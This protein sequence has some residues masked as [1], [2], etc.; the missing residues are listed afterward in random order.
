MEQIVYA[1]TNAEFLNE[2]FGTNYKAWMKC[3]WNYDEDT[4]VWMV[5][6]DDK[7]RQGWKNTIVDVETVREDYLG[8]EEDKLGGHRK[9]KNY[10]RIVVKKDRKNGIYTVLGLYAYDFENS[11]EKNKRI[12]KK[13]SD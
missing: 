3:G 13:I 4:I 2:A 12:W 9:L 8:R 10:R 7:V 5:E 6:L 11:I 1:R